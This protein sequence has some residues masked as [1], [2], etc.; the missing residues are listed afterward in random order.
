MLTCWTCDGDTDTVRNNW[1][2]CHIALVLVL[3]SLL[4]QTGYLE[5]ACTSVTIRCNIVVYAQDN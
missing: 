4:V 3:G 1:Q 2:V 5:M